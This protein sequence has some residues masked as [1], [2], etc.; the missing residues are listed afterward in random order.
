MLHGFGDKDKLWFMLISVHKGENTHRNLLR[1]AT[2]WI[3]VKTKNIFDDGKDLE[4]TGAN[5]MSVSTEWVAST[6][7][8]LGRYFSAWVA[9]H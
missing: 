2:M 3:K 1:L 4:E 8:V 5:A 6:V 7:S 9:G